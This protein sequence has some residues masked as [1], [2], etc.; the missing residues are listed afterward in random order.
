M[1]LLQKLQSEGEEDK[2]YE[3]ENVS[4]S[5]ILFQNLN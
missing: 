1:R 2:F 5:G 4:T 3:Y